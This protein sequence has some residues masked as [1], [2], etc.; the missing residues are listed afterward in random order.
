LSLI[1]DTLSSILS[2]LIQTLS[3]EYLFDLLS[4]SFL[5]FQNFYIFIKFL[6]NILHCLFSFSCLF[7]SSL[8]SFIFLNTSSFISLIILTIMLLSSFGFLPLHYPLV[9]LLLWGHL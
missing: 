9:H 5:E 2:T 8:N 1:P 6:F 4:F 3:T 7:V